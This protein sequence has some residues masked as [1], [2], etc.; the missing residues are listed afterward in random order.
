MDY[1]NSGIFSKNK[2]KTTDK[3]PD[4]TGSATVGGQ[5]YWMDV[6]ANEKDGRRYFTAK[7]KLKNP[8]PAEEPVRQV[9]DDVPS[10]VLDDEIPF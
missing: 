8:M 9:Q 5:E 2:R 3:H 1:D 7:F 6:Y 4:L 10:H